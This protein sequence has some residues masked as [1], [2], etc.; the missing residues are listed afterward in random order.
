MLS[1]FSPHLQ[2]ETVADLSVDRL[3]SLKI[4]AL[5]LDVDCTLKRYGSNEMSPDLV[6][7]L[8]QLRKA[9]L[10]LCLVSNGRGNRI[11]SF[12]DKVGLSFVAGACKPFPFGCRSAIRKMG[13]SKDKTAMVGDQVFADVVAGRLAGLFTILVRPIKPE[14]E[15]WFT[16]MK[17]PFER[18]V[19]ERLR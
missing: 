2:V 14:E 9:N 11:R 3:R 1:I 5:L 13:F 8:E 4:E 17:R 15:P 7:W 10:G 12:A 19:L 18:R 6:N 16:R